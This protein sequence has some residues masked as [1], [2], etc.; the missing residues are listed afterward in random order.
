LEAYY[1]IVDSPRSVSYR[2]PPRLRVFYYR[3]VIFFGGRTRSA[4]KPL[5]IASASWRCRLLPRA[6]VDFGRTPA[7][8]VSR[9]RNRNW[10]RLRPQPKAGVVGRTC[11]RHRPG[12]GYF[13]GY[14]TMPAARRD[15]T[16]LRVLENQ[17]ALVLPS[18]SGERDLFIKHGGCQ[19]PQPGNAPPAGRWD[20]RKLPCLDPKTNR[21]G[22]PRRICGGGPGSDLWTRGGIPEANIRHAAAPVARPMP[23]GQGRPFNVWPGKLAVG[24]LVSFGNG[25]CASAQ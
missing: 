12:K 7:G 24:R 5:L 6:R 19:R 20:R 14:L 10:W 22:G 8:E 11:P 23:K 4:Q 13:H 2:P 15:P 18:G 3:G 9:P 25:R 16:H 17:L 21:R 1:Y